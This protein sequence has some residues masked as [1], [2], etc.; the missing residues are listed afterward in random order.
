MARASIHFSSMAAA[1]PAPGFLYFND[2]FNRN[3]CA[4]VRS[5]F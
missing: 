2:T 1:F 3:R 5:R 4:N